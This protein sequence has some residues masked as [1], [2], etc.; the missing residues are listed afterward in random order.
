MVFRGSNSF[1][2]TLIE[3]VVRWNG[4]FDNLVLKG[5]FGQLWCRVIKPICTRREDHRRSFISGVIAEILVRH[6][7]DHFIG[8]HGL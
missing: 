5:K 6:R 4:E 8:S 7:N 2:F 3:F 1:V